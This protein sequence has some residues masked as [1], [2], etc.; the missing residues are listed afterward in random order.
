MFFFFN[1]KYFKIIFFSKINVG[2]EKNNF[3]IH[4]KISVPTSLGIKARLEGVK[5]GETADSP[6]VSF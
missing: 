3:Y 1:L 6:I 2:D 5:L 4:L